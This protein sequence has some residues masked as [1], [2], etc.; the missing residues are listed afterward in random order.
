MPGRIAMSE[1]TDKGLLRLLTCGSVDDGKS[2]LIG[3]LLHDADLIMSDQL[4]ALQH[5]SRRFGTTDGEIDFSLLLDGLEEERQQRITID[6]AYRFFSTPRRSFIVADTPGHQQY[7][8]N[9]ATGASTAELAVL[10]VDARKGVL[11]QT[12]RHSRICSLF[13][14]R[15]I[16]LAVNKLDLLGFEQAAFDRIAADYERFAADLGFA[17][18]TMIPLSARY[19]DN[20]AERSP[21]MPWYGGPSLLEFLE[22]VELADDPGDRSFR[23]PVQWINRPHGDFRGCAGTVTA[24]SVVP[25]DP[26]VVMGSAHASRIKEIVTFDGPLARAAAGDAVTLVLEDAIDVARGDLLVQ[27]QAPAEFA[28]QFAAHLVWMKEEALVPGRSYWLKLGARTVSATVTALKHRIDVD[29][30]T[31]VAARRLDLNEIGFCNLATSLPVA[32]DPYAKCRDTGGFI[33]VDRLTQETAAAGVIAFALRRAGNI[34]QHEPTVSTGQ[35]AGLKGHQPAVLWFTGLSGAGKS[36]IANL[37]E[38][39]LLAIGCHTMLLDGDNIRLGLNRDLGFT[40]ADRVENI[41]RAGQVA[42]LMSDAGLIVICAFISPF[43]A[44]RQMARDAAAPHPFVEIFVD[45]PLAE[46]QRRDPKGLY[47]K[48]V[49]GA[50]P[51]FTG[52][53]S[54]YEPPQNPEVSLSTVD[55]DPEILAGRLVEELRHR[56]ILA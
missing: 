2:T 26:V 48:A 10:L 15:R 53:N 28:D 19:G 54:P 5:D 52:I 51:N 21:R 41:R 23:F 14:I 11:V 42:R 34:H 50:I 30:G 3:R 27:P 37:L 39:K 56:G 24:G 43:H 31:Q 22:S 38:Q 25:G 20:V 46:C 8:R 17:S 49:A 7:T 4:A 12:M 29:S 18:L 35:R 13:G 47:A 32:F 9:M 55:H 45:T 36:T 40:D 6:V 44:D 16:V 33:L 1:T